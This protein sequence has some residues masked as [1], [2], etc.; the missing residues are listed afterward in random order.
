MSG[1]ILHTWRLPFWSSNCYLFLFMFFLCFF[2]F[3]SFYLYLYCLCLFFSYSGFLITVYESQL[4]FYAAEKI[5]LQ[6]IDSANRE[7]CFLYGV[8]IS[9]FSEVCWY[10]KECNKNVLVCSFQNMGIFN[11]TNVYTSC[12]NVFWTYHDPKCVLFIRVNM[13]LHLH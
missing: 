10:L 9:S 13:N 3:S 8:A 2:F 11:M 12:V 1:I 5:L 6:S 4:F 7:I